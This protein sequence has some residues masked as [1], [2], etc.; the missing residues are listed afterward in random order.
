MSRMLVYTSPARGHLYPVVRIMQELHRRGHEVALRTLASQVGLA[1]ELGLD[2]APVDPR[3]EAIELDDYEA[4]SQAGRGRRALATFA[5]R[6]EHELGDLRGALDAERPDALLVDCMTWGAAAVAQAWGGPWA[7]FVPYP[8][9]LPSR[10]V[11]PFGLGLHPARGPLGRVRDR[12]LGPLATAMFNR[13]ALGPLNRM[14]ARVGVAP[15]V[16]AA[17]A[18]A[19]APLVLYLTSEP[20]EYP[21]GDWPAGICMVGPCAWDPPAPAPAWLER[22]GREL[23]LVST[24]S[25]RQRDRRLVTVA[26]EAFAGEDIEL[27]A[28]LP[29]EG[30]EGI[31][32]PANAHVER[33]LPHAPLLERAACAVTH[34]GAGI[35]QKAL[36]AGVPVCAVPFGRDQREV[37]RRV[38]VAGA[39][40]RLPVARLT[41]RRLRERVYEAIAMRSGAERVARA[42]AAAGGP[43]AAADAFERLMRATPP[44]ADQATPPSADQAMPPPADQVIPPS[45]DQAMPP[46]AG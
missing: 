38:E 6:A 40:R 11:P 18:L 15:L 32:V 16:N 10:E 21:R 24:S 2:A 45:A 9:P 1:R 17:D 5:A 14:R 27:V 28:T 29:A 33:F 34:G 35:T 8:L 23:V 12:A 30:V 25:E 42:F 39:G 41:A 26:L 43:V 7:Q 20:F 46:P 19:I 13:G 22:V 36:A 44:S 3:I 31:E 37:A 4:R